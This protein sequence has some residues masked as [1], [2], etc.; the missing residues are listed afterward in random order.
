[1]A[2]DPAGLW[3]ALAY[4]IWSL[5]PSGKQ[6]EA[7]GGEVPAVTYRE[8]AV[9]VARIFAKVGVYE[10]PWETADEQGRPVT[11][12][13]NWGEAYL[14]GDPHDADHLLPFCIANMSWYFRDVPRQGFGRPPAPGWEGPSWCSMFA[15]YGLYE[16]GLFGAKQVRAPGTAKGS[17]MSYA[18]CGSFVGPGFRGWKRAQ[19]QVFEG[20]AAVARRPGEDQFT[21]DLFILQSRTEGEKEWH[22]QAHV[23]FVEW[24]TTRAG[25]VV[26]HTIE[27]NTPKGLVERRELTVRPDGTVE[28][29][30]QHDRTER[31]LE[32]YVHVD[33]DIP[34]E[35]VNRTAARLLWLL[36]Q[37]A[38]YRP[39]VTW[40]P[41]EFAVGRGQAPTVPM[42][43]AWV[44]FNDVV[45]CPP[46][47]VEAFL[48]GFDAAQG[49]P[50]TFTQAIAEWYFRYLMPWLPPR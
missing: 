2:R 44:A 43:D 24:A 36:R 26:L 39:G 19:A 15:W 8:T 7:N 3:G 20:Q 27:G 35:N 46:G 33:A 29:K 40:E 47:F 9:E 31:K 22:S 48:A 28:V 34:W 11:S 6:W 50:P 13:R 23:G 41:S 17:I 32:Y 10:E 14:P 5:T 42:D 16:A 49:R 37:A 30:G 4:Y 1:M 21:G 12:H 18:H 38:R 25:E 45:G